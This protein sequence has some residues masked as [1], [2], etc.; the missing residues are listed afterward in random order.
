MPAQTKRRDDSSSV[1]AAAQRF[2]PRCTQEQRRKHQCPEDA[3]AAR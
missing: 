2:A 1:I 3:P